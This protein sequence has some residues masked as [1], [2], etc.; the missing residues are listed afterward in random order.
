MLIVREKRAI[1]SN[2]GDKIAL[3]TLS[4]YVIIFLVTRPEVKKDIFPKTL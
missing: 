2:K 1:F 3:L 4:V